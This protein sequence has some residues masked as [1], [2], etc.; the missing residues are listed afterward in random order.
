MRL[1]SI[2]SGYCAMS[3]KMIYVWTLQRRLS[4]SSGLLLDTIP[5]ILEISLPS[6]CLLQKALGFVWHRTW[7]HKQDGV[8]KKV[9]KRTCRSKTRVGNRRMVWYKT[10]RNPCSRQEKL[11]P[12]WALGWRAARAA[13]LDVDQRARTILSPALWAVV[14]QTAGFRGNS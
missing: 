1:I 6:L 5:R 7:I 9:G 3:V 12:H 13:P 14:L 4:L 8:R 2:Q 11:C 10:L